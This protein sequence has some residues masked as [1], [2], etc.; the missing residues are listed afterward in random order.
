MYFKGGSLR[1]WW[2]QCRTGGAFCQ[3]KLLLLCNALRQSSN[4]DSLLPTSM[5]SKLIAP[6][7][8]VGIFSEDMMCSFSE[9][10]VN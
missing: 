1:L 2:L 10:I 4:D 3:Q 8:E 5:R 9:S 7:L 6:A